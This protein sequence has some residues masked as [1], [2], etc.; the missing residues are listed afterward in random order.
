LSSSP[1]PALASPSNFTRE[2]NVISN[3]PLEST[4]RTSIPTGV[5]ART[6]PEIEAEEGLEGG[7]E[8]GKR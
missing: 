1:N 4:P 2:P 6:L 7:N 5:V 3:A 8:V